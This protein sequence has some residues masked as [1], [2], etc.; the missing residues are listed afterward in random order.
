M[1]GAAFSDLPE[2]RYKAGTPGRGDTVQ[3][4]G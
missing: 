1:K 3:V 4:F 2:V